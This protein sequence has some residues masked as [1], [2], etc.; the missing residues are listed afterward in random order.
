VLYWKEDDGT[1]RSRALAASDPGGAGPSP[2]AGAG[3]LA[4]EEGHPA[5]LA[6]RTGQIQRLSPLAD[7]AREALARELGPEPADGAPIHSALWVP[8]VARSHTLGALGLYRREG[9]RTHDDFDLWLAGELGSRAALAIDN[10]RLYGESRQAV[11]ARDEVVSVVSH[12]LRNPLNSIVLSADFA[13]LLLD[14]EAD[15][16]EI[17]A[18]LRAVLRSARQMNDLVED[19]VET[20]RLE[21]GRLVLDRE[22]VEIAPLLEEMRD[23]FAAPAEERSIRLVLE[24]EDGL[25][26]VQADRRRLEQVLSNLVGNALKFTEP[27]GV[28]TMRARA[29]DARVVLAVEDTGIGIPAEHIPH[30]FDRF[31]QAR[32]SDRRGL[33]LG[34]PIVKGLDE[35]HGGEVWVESREG[36]GTTVS[37]TLPSFTG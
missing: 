5:W 14:R 9:A 6:V 15:R 35:A 33:G 22:T 7:D 27:G 17:A 19:L 11:R 2:D 16:D 8:I 25:P 24:V 30:L 18:R 12:D 10:A 34:L 3:A 36:V 13:L 4:A 20:T 28:V 29:D 26:P 1:L 21:S 23:A 31:W 37:F 32:R